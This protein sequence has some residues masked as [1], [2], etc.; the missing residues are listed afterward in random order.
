MTN[1]LGFPIQVGRQGN[2][3]AP[4][5]ACNMSPNT[6]ER[7]TTSSRHHINRDQRLLRTDLSY[8]TFLRSSEAIVGFGLKAIQFFDPNNNE[9]ASKI[10]DARAF[11]H[12]MHMIRSSSNFNEKLL[13]EVQYDIM[14]EVVLEKYTQSQS[15]KDSLLKTG[16]LEIVEASEDSYWG[17][18]IGTIEAHAGIPWRGQNM[19]GKVFMEVRDMLRH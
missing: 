5:G 13:N 10:L 1:R 14:L 15:F 12:M 16:T 2:P 8:E 7:R 6:E 9:L 17:I 4:S 11:D 18:G 19:L 3:F